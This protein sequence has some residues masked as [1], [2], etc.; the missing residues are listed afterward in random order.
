MASIAAKLTTV[1]VNLAPV[2]ASWRVL[3]SYRSDFEGSSVEVGVRP[4]S[5]GR[6]EG[7]VNGRPYEVQWRAWRRPVPV[8]LNSVG[9]VA[10]VPSVMLQWRGWPHRADGDGVDRSRWPD[11]TA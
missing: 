6:L 2:E 10:T 3:C 5:A 8:R 7:G 4:P 9:D 1:P 11:V